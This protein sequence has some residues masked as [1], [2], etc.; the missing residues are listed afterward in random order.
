MENPL[1]P[2]WSG[3]YGGVPPFDQVEVAHFKPALEEAMQKQLGEIRRI[4]DSPA[5]PTFENT[6]AF[7]AVEREM[8]PKLSAFRDLIVQDERLF[9]RISAVYEA[10][11]TSRLTPEQQR[12]TW[13]QYRNFA[14]SGA[15]LDALS[16]EKLSALNQ[17]LATLYTGFSHNVL[18]DEASYILIE[19]EG[20]LA[21][22]PESFR[23]GAAEAAAGRGKA[24]QWAILNTRSSVEP[25]LTYSDRRELREKVWRA[26]I[27]RGDNGDKH[28]NKAII[29][30][31][32]KLRDERAHLL[33]Y[34][35]HAHWRVE[36]SMA[37][38]PERATELMQALWKPAVARVGEEVVDMQAMAEKDGANIS[39]EPWDYRYYAEKV[40][41]ARFDVDDNAVTPYL[42]LEKLREAM[43]WVAGE[44]L[45]LRFSRAEGV[46]VY[47][48]DVRVWEVRNET[49]KHVALFYFDPYA[50]EGKR[51]GAWM[52]A[53]RN[54]ERFDG[55]VTTLVS[56]NC[57]FVKGKP[58]EPVLVSWSDAITLFHEFGHALHGISSSVK[59]PSLSGTNVD[60]DYVE[61]PSQLL[62][63]WLPT[64]EV[65]NR[66]AR[67]W[68]TDQP[69]PRELVAKIERA[70]MFNKGFDNVEYLS[71]ALVD[72]R[73]HLEPAK[74]RDIDAFERETLVALGMPKQMVMRHRLTQFGHLFSGDSYSAGY[75]SYLWADTL[76]A[77]AFEAFT[78][79]VAGR[80][81][82][83][84][85]S[86][87]NTVDPAEGYR[88]FRGR[89]AKIDALMRRRGFGAP[90]SQ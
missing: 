58:G 73:M 69:I 26:F 68:K 32:V 33:G 35:S 77:D 83:H 11:E 13:L 20:D 59:Y 72:M 21:G 89:D 54:Q 29:A 41:K 7:Q 42:Q 37:K 53:Y 44:L 49:G 5:P 90:A 78:E 10:R 45:G 88:A 50:R 1:L 86:V 79:A 17:R 75:Y 63:Q 9:K 39:I 76:S 71:S 66:F 24:G 85:F 47:H 16:K 36:M 2:R 15:K 51:S 8:E 27:N 48:P 56:N 57:N 12:L 38:T 40:R 19:K 14:R 25:F 52:N 43:F 74:A 46:P 6:E 62:E 22:L 31:I 70:A 61:F 82:T 87:G 3:P 81:R 34:P 18:A 65:L 64:Q 55:E 60:R 84:V 30:E 23:S 67:H 4:D 28:D 80:L